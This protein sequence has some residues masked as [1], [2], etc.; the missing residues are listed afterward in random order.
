[1]NTAKIVAVTE[2]LIEGVN[3]AEEFIAYAKAQKNPFD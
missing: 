3:S 2:P 1:M